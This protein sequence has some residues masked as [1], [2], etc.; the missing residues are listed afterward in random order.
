MSNV[1][2]YLLFVRGLRIFGYHGWY[3]EERQ[4]GQYYLVDV[5]FKL[6]LKTGNS[7][8][9]AD[10]VNYEPLSKRIRE[11][12]AEPAQ[13]I[14]ELARRIYT[15]LAENYPAAIGLGVEVYKLHPP[16]NDL[17]SASVR[18]DPQQLLH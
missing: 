8:D 17:A 16:V 11:L 4:L 14:E 3:E 6:P 12:F 2:T 18:I 13:L 9:L 15:D 10:T 1:E 5:A 7:E